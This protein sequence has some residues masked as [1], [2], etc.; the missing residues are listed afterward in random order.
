VAGDPLAV[1]TYK[2]AILAAE[3]GRA[4]DVKVA[5]EAALAHLL[6]NRRRFDESREWLALG[7]ATAAHADHRLEARLWKVEGWLEYEQDHFDRSNEAF[8]HA[9]PAYAEF[10]PRSPDYALTM[11][12]AAMVALMAGDAPRATELSAASDA[13]AIGLFGEGSAFRAG[14][15]S[16]RAALLLE[17]ARYEE[18]LAAS[19][20]ALALASGLPATQNRVMMA[21]FNRVEALLGLARIDE[22]RADLETE[23]RILGAAGMDTLR[24][25]YGR[26]WR[27][28]RAKLFV[29]AGEHAAALPILRELIPDRR[30]G[31]APSGASP[32][33][34]D[35]DD[36]VDDSVS[37]SLF[38]EAELG[39]H[40][41][42]EAI[43]HLR[44]A[45]AIMAREKLATPARLEEVA[46]ANLLLGEALIDAGGDRA[47]ARRALD[48][49]SA[50]N[51]VPQ[52]RGELDVY[53][54]RLAASRP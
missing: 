31:T 44:A 50:A 38:G 3:R 12:G 20:A 30:R 48:A 9:L 8:K 39:L 11:S 19:D 36:D 42:R 23:T 24:E 6:A 41:P 33:A 15:L 35:E 43:P 26:K 40:A 14:I 29:L 2:E 10:F 22:A 16:N 34:S 5:A 7:R 49:V 51:L 17:G 46:V 53:R 27:R 4:D 13:L 37:Q 1:D 47:E 28:L 32:A 21:H 25:D 52:R 45:V 54:A 18:A